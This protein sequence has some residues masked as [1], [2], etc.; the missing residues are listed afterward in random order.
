MDPGQSTKEH[1]HRH[2]P[3]ESPPQPVTASTASSNR[4]EDIHHRKSGVHPYTTKDRHTATFPHGP[5]SD[6]SHL[7][8][9]TTKDRHTTTFPHGPS[10]DTPHLHA[11]T[12]KD[13]HTTTFPN[14]STIKDIPS[15]PPT[16]ITPEEGRHRHH[17]H[18]HHHHSHRHK[19]DDEQ[20]PSEPDERVISPSDIDIDTA[21]KTDV[22]SY[23][24]PKPHWYS[25]LM[26][27]WPKTA[28]GENLLNISPMHIHVIVLRP[29]GAIHLHLC[30][31][32][33]CFKISINR[34]P[35][36][37]TQ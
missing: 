5:S 9:Y 24:H 18:H 35:L 26:V 15:P 34:S 16:P 22:T 31:T 2:K 10:S 20:Q 3:A 23:G 14:S 8:A 29:E 37:Y 25:S 13:R 4:Q 28:F 32:C 19:K 30:Q 6:E 12:T 36:K 21:S 17:K 7:H 27:K 11:Y 33:Q 1:K